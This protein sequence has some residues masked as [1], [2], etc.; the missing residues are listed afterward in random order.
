MTMRI[1]LTVA[2]G[3]ALALL[4]TPCAAVAQI[5]P[6]IG[7]I[8]PVYRYVDPPYRAYR[9]GPA[10]HRHAHRSEPL[11]AAPA[12]ENGGQDAAKA[13]KNGSGD[14]NTSKPPEGENGDR[15]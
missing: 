5:S 4:L 12:P 11:D 13:S 3:A 9:H 1:L 15:M 7:P 2:S 6:C 8:P 10:T 14:Q